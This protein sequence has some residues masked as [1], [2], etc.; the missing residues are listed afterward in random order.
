[1][2]NID[3]TNVDSTYSEYFGEPETGESF[4]YGYGFEA[5]QEFEPAG[6]DGQR[7]LFSET[8]EMDLA[9]EL[10]TVSND[11]ELEQFLGKLFRKVSKAVGGFIKSPVGRSLGEALKGIVKQALPAAGM[12]L[13]NVIAP[14]AGG[15]IGGQLGSAAGKIFGLELEALSPED[16]ELEI[17]R[18]V[19][20]LA[21]AAA[22]NA[23]QASPSTPPQ[24]VVQSALTAAAQQYAPGLLRGG[25]A[26]GAGGLFGK[27]QQ[28]NNGRWV[29]RGNA[30]ILMGA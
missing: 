8:E 4:G 12:A 26:K 22:S 20:R 10:L 29:R 19:V 25:R 3:R 15:A 21:G 24:Q 16:Q 30:I 7:G 17:A 1:M 27:R 14:G 13:G 28:R 23:A 11:A 18:G 2:H 9:T 5:E 6:E